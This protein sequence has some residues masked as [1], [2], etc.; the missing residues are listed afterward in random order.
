MTNRRLQN[1]FW[2]S[3]IHPIYRYSKYFILLKLWMAFSQFKFS[4]DIYLRSFLNNK[5]IIDFVNVLFQHMEMWRTISKLAESDK[6]RDRYCTYNPRVKMS[7]SRY[8]LVTLWIFYSDVPTEIWQTTFVLCSF[9]I[10]SIFL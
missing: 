10:D 5:D 6:I 8:R 3:L 4:R 9:S 2:E 7:S 1:S